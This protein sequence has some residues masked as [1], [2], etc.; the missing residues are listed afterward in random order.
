MSRPKAQDLI[1]VV[2]NP[3]EH[4]SAAQP[5]A[6]ALLFD[7]QEP[8][9]FPEMNIFPL[10]WRVETPM[11][12]QI[13]DQ[14]RTPGWS[15]HTLPWD[16]LKADDFSLDERYAM[17]YWFTLLSV[18][19]GSGPA[20]FS[21]A[22]IHTW[23]THEEDPVR[24]CFFSIVRDE[25]NHEE[26][27]QRAIQILTPN[28]PLGY[29][30]ETPL[31]RLARNNVKWYYHNGCRYW[32]GFKNGITKFQ[33]PILFAS[34]LMGEVAAATLFH[35]MYQRTTMPVLKEAFK[36]IGKDE[37]RHMAICLAVLRN[38]L[39]RLTDE[40]RDVITRQIRAGFVFLSGILYVP[41]T[42]FWELGPTFRP[43]HRM[44]EE[45]ARAAGLGIL[46]EDE[47]AE[48]WRAAVLQLKGILEPH[49]VEFPALPEIGVDG[50]TVAIDPQDIIPVF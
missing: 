7:A 38:V 43:A 50:K 6:V 3:P 29:E 39:P 21:R 12:Q 4:S 44:L 20:V 46:T 16:T 25:V 8:P 1:G 45:A 36:M 49:G 18:F 9:P 34:F 27:C 30:L 19:D 11:L 17:A 31:G 23:E 26:V 22:F 47:R 24:K 13:Y 40:Q 37:A 28:G 32:T 10:E 35:S 2:E 42:D 48:N 5:D 41:P 15:P 14:A 33:L